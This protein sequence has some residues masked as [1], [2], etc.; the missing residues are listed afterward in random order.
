MLLNTHDT[1][2]EF[3]LSKKM[4]ADR[5]M[6]VRGGSDERVED[7]LGWAGERGPEETF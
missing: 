6:A 7:W 3:H 1:L 2:L 5:R 4:L